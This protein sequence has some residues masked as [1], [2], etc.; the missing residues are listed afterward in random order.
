MFL[1]YVRI[2]TFSAS[3][4]SRP[5]PSCFLCVPYACHHPCTKCMKYIALNQKHRMS[6]LCK[7][8]CVCGFLWICS[9]FG[10]LHHNNGKSCRN[11]TKG[12]AVACSFWWITSAWV[13]TDCRW[14][15]PM[16][17][18]VL[19]RTPTLLDL[20]YI[21]AVYKTDNLNFKYIFLYF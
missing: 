17:K 5:C 18:C 20:L 14:F 6:L 13:S 9:K 7:S 3:T 2:W 21:K 11:P 16:G 8:V 1:P 4:S 19:C 10:C 12:C 15:L